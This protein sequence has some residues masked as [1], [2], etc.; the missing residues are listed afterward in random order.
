MRSDRRTSSISGHALELPAAAVK[1]M[2]AQLSTLADDVVAAIVEPSLAN[3]KPD[4]KFQF[5][6]LG[7]FVADCVDH[8]EGKPVFNLAVGLKDSWGK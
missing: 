4:D 7:Y 5:E 3:A 8:A 6:R 2:R 1:E